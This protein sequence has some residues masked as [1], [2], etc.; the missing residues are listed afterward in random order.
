M[1]NSVAILFRVLVFRQLWVYLSV[2]IFYLRFNYCA[3]VYISKFC[4]LKIVSEVVDSRKWSAKWKNWNISEYSSLVGA[5]TF[6]KGVQIYETKLKLENGIMQFNRILASAIQGVREISAIIVTDN[7][8]RYKEQKSPYNFC[9]I[10]IFN[11][12][13]TF[14]TSDEWQHYFG[15]LNNVGTA[16]GFNRFLRKFK[17]IESSKCTLHI[18]QFLFKYMA[19]FLINP[20][21]CSI[22]STSLPWKKLK[23][24]IIRSNAN[25][26]CTKFI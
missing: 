16:S 11:E 9:H 3:S 17:N 21:F 22:Q 13:F 25:L 18:V 14:K 23:H 7:Y 8:L 4:H 19:Y 12:L 26:N 10:L 6:L 1:D 20:L 5:Q 2:V 15:M 24:F